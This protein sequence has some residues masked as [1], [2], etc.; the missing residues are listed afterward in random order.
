LEILADARARQI[1]DVRPGRPYSINRLPELH[2][3][4]RRSTMMTTDSPAMIGARVDRVE[5]SRLTSGRGRYLDDVNPP[6]CLHLRL[7]RS[8][9]PRARIDAIDMERSEGDTTDAV[10][11]TGDDLGEYGIRAD[12]SGAG[13]SALQPVLA[14]GHARYVGEPVA[15]VLHTDPY[16]AEDAAEEVAIDYTP[17]DPV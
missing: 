12:T 7:V 14:R 10:L 3:L 9:H 17:L 2:F 15:A 6:G 13:Q 5:D 11:F 16:V 8:P 1:Y 4:P